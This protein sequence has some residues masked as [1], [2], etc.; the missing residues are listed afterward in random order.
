M[1]NLANLLVQEL[2]A[3][4]VEIVFGLPGGEIVPVIDGL[5]RWGIRLV[6][7]YHETT[8][9]FMAAVTAR[10]TGKPAVCLTTLGP[11]ATN[12]V[13]GVAHAFLDRAPI[14]VITAQSAALDHEPRLNTHQV[15]DGEAMFS[16]ITKASLRLT[17]IKPQALLSKAYAFMTQD[18]P[19]PVNLRLVNEDALKLVKAEMSDPHPDSDA[20]RIR[21]TANINGDVE[22]ATQTLAQAK[23]PILVLG[24]GVEPEAPYEAIRALAEAIQAPVIVT[25]KAK[26]AFPAD[27]PL[28]VGVIGLTRTDP[29]Y[30]ILDEA[31]CI[32]AIGF[33][34]VELVK[35][36]DQTAPLIWLAQWENH[37]PILENTRAELVGSM[38][39]ALQDLQ[40]ISV[41]TQPDWGEV[42]VTQFRRILAEQV[43][44]KPAEGR[45]LPQTVLKTLHDMLPREA[46]LTVDVGSH[47]I[48]FSLNWPTYTPNRFMLSNGLS[49]MGYGLPAAIAASLALP[50]EVV[51]CITGDAGL[52]MCLGELGLI[53]Q[54]NTAIIMIVMNDCA[55]D[56]I[57]SHQIRSGYEPHG[58]EFTNPDFVAIAKGY[59][60]D[61]Y[62]VQDEVELRAALQTALDTRQ[63]TLIEAMIDPISYPTTPVKEVEVGQVY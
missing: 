20:S 24:L 10:V 12:V 49:C 41:K 23:Q 47:K 25:P 45:M 8:A 48:F 5:R 36:W 58:T 52:S 37:D 46:M 62:R 32:I 31:D 7:V 3:R 55:L 50:D 63:A 15:I 11:G 17:E 57:R 6:M 61:A 40:K 19:G 18:Q 21:D 51:V 43:L 2:K 59:Q 56:L 54:L 53:N 28:F 34:V 39:L 16:P 29:A 35:T 60:L 9:A 38:S 14:L 44:P 13:S 22:K 1:Q 33:D 42:R 30:Q 4:G 27:H 26:G